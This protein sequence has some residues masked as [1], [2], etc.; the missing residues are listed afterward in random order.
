MHLPYVYVLLAYILTY[1]LGYLT[2]T[3]KAGKKSI[4]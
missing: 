1:A 2:Y 3:K 4:D